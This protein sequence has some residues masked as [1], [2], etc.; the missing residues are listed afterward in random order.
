MPTFVP[1]DYLFQNHADK[2]KEKHEIYAWAV[3]EIMSTAGDM[4]TNE[5]HFREKL[6]YEVTLGF[7]KKEKE[8]PEVRQEREPLLQD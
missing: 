2:G 1:N 3:R 7:R 5:S 6:Q 4:K 8:I